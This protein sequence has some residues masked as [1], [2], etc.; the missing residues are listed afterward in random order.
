MHEERR[1]KDVWR[2]L[3]LVRHGES[4]ANEVNRFAGAIDAPLTELGKAQARR[5]GS[6]WK[7]DD[8]DEVYVS[9]LTR[10][11][12]TAQ[13]I[14]DTLPE[15]TAPKDSTRLD[16][17]ISER[18]F[19]EFTLKNK[20]R[21]QR[22]FGLRN[23]EASLYQGDASLH[24]GESFEAFRDRV[25]EFLRNEL[26]PALSSGKKVLVVAHKYVIE[27]LSRMILRLPE[28]DGYD[29][30]LPNARI[31]PG[32][33]L[34]QYVRAE[35]PARNRLN[36]WI[37]VHHSV[38]LSCAAVLGLALNAIGLGIA[39]P[40]WLL[41]SLLMVATTISLARISLRNP[42]ALAD[43]N[44]LSARQLLIRFVVLPWAITGLGSWLWPPHGENISSTLA[45]IA[46]L[47]AAP[48][49]V[50]ATILSRSAGGMILP[51][52]FMILLSTAMSAANTI[53]LLAWFDMSDLAFQALVFVGLSIS[54]LLLPMLAAYFMRTQYPIATAKYAEDHASTAVLSLALFVILAFQNIQL[55][56]FYPMGLTAIAIGLGLRLLAVR[57]ARHRSLYS[58]DDYFSISY[59]NIFLVILLANLVG[60]AA[61]LEL[62][63]WF[64]VPMF[65]L[66]PLD[67]WLIH[68]LQKAQPEFSLM[69]YLRIHHA[70]E[71]M[72]NASKSGTGP[73]ADTKY[74]SVNDRASERFDR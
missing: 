21:L 72:A 12:Q 48:T 38:V 53:A 46:L 71:Q 36:D 68:R 43:P 47:V 5:A 7:G 13:I 25:L 22:H 6:Q 67:D 39:I 1:Q 18:F 4:T 55:S 24:G 9:P 59:P 30:R 66:T 29:L 49:A 60:N 51:C 14:L 16:E 44:L 17:R 45:A 15:H 33:E 73:L 32:C 40:S 31:L 52:V 56:T 63:T 65:I 23:Y 8:I 27:L 20:T 35:S 26:Y 64:L 70:E 19:G 37:V 50:T 41:L 34:A 10:A 3:Y 61:A 42:S 57:I 69:K 28:V 58:L 2:N 62:A 54:T 74:R 11:R